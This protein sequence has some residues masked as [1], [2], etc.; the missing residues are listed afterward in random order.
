[1]NKIVEMQFGSHVYGTN[2]PTSDIDLKAVFLPSAKDILLQRVPRTVHTT[3]KKDPHGKNSADDIDFEAFSLQQYMKLLL[4][5]QTVALDMLFTP[6]EFWRYHTETWLNIKRCYLSFMHSGI[7][8]FVG[9]CRTQ[10]NKYGIKGSRMRAIRDTAEFLRGQPQTDR[11]YV[12]RVLLGIIERDLHFLKGVEGPLVGFVKLK[13]KRTQEYV[14]YFEVCGRKFQLGITVGE[15][16]SR[17]DKI[18]EE[19]GHRARKAE[20]NEGIDW[21]ALM[22]AVRI[23]GQA[24]ELL[25]TG[26]VT[27]PRP[28]ADLLLKI[29]KGE[30]PYKMVSEIIEEGLK[31]LVVMQ[32]RSSL[33]DKPNYDVAEG[34]VLN[35]HL[36]EIKKPPLDRTV[37]QGF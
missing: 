7:L 37:K 29:R 23:Q 17:L 14:D 24:K 8:S 20:K 9:Y 26:H 33:P 19:Y 6:E 12:H 28:D 35:A 18:Y 21:K 4:E 5:G 30:L 16:I 3:T 15:A 36:N 1:M 31:D 32:R 25:D 13:D 2:L 22:H 34:I 11:L 27:F 10:A